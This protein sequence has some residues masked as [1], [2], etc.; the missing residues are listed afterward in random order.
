MEK[1]LATCL[2]K[3]TL[4]WETLQAN[5]IE[6]VDKVLAI[7]DE[8]GYKLDDDGKVINKQKKKLEECIDIPL[9]ILYNDNCKK[10]ADRER[11]GRVW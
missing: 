9:F 4:S 1:F 2:I 11:V 5:K 10:S 8:R 7:L 3:G 6:Y